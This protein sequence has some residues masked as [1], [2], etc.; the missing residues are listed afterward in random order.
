MRPV[1]LWCGREQRNYL[2]CPDKTKQSWEFKAI[3]SNQI[4]KLISVP[5]IASVLFGM[6]YFMARVQ[7]IP[8]DFTIYLTMS[9][10]GGSPLKVE[11]PQFRDHQIYSSV[12]KESFCLLQWGEI[13]SNPSQK[14][15]LYYFS[16]S[17]SSF[18]L[19]LLSRSSILLQ[20]PL[21]Q[22]HY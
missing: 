12:K 1:F 2:S 16:L 21:T 9:Q 15:P 10:S 22:F 17:V 14:S 7:S 20:W 18:V 6:L 19:C 13:Q 11:L 5:Q 3:P 4:W 8:M